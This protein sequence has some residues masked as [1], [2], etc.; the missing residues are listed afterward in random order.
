MSDTLERVFSMQ[1][2]SLKYPL[3]KTFKK[4]LKEFELVLS[5]KRTRERKINIEEKKTEL[6]KKKKFQS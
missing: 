4:I 5:E 3:E 2:L 6:D 1:E